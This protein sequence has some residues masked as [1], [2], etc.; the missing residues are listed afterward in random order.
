M[1]TQF[2][3][4]HA[5]IK[6]YCSVFGVLITEVRKFTVSEPRPYAQY[7]TSVDVSFVKPRQRRSYSYTIVPDGIRYLTIERNGDVVY[8][9]RTDVPYMPSPCS[10]S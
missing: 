8:D 6:Q 4:G 7:P 5:M 2:E 9:S 1:K 10:P 3:G